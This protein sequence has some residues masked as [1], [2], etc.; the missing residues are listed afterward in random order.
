MRSKFGRAQGG[1][2]SEHTLDNVGPRKFIVVDQDGVPITEQIPILRY[3]AQF[4]PLVL[5]VFSGN[6]SV[7]GW[8]HVGGLAQEFVDKFFDHAESLGADHALRNPMQF[9]RVPAGRHKNGNLQKV[10]FF[11]PDAINP[12]QL[13][14]AISPNSQPDVAP[15][16]SASSPE[17][18]PDPPLQ[19]Q[20]NANH[21]ATRDR[22]NLQLLSANS[23]L[24][25]APASVASLLPPK[26]PPDIRAILETAPPFGNGLLLWIRAAALTLLRGREPREVAQFLYLVTKHYP[27]LRTEILVLKSR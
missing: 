7:H 17:N 22:S 1:Y 14:A 10:F 5:I 24:T 26:L 15:A 21:F 25:L 18:D 3:L 27:A 8:F 13:P 12:R 23:P 16:A 20:A 19:D 9:V 2:L 11:D 6:E 4:L